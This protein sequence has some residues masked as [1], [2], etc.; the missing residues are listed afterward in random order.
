MNDPAGTDLLSLA[1]DNTEPFV[2]KPGHIYWITVQGDWQNGL[3][4]Q[5]DARYVSAE[6][7][8]T[9]AEGIDSTTLNLE[10]QINDEFV[11]W[12][13]YNADHNCSYWITGDG[14]PIN[15]RVFEGDP[16]T[17]APYPA[18]YIDNEGPVGGVAMPAIVF[19][20]ALPS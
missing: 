2:T 11:D 16:A 17:N 9:W 5:V 3:T 13:A 20:Y 19:E 18:W 4:Y 12:G 14:N 15:M 1:S 6:G 10:T 7:W 8:L